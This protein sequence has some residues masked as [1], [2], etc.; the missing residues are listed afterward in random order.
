MSFAIDRAR[1]VIFAVTSAVAML[2]MSSQAQ[3]MMRPD[4]MGRQGAVVSDHALASA[5]GAAVLRNGGAHRKHGV[6]RVGGDGHQCR[7]RHYVIILT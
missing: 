7:A 3:S 2:P 4:V 5:A 1:R 6:S